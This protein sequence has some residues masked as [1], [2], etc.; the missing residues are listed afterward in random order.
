[1]YLS[2]S[3][4]FSDMNL[5]GLAGWL[6]VQRLEEITHA[7]KMYDY[8]I[9]RGGR[10]L[11]KAIDGPPTE[12]DSPLACAE[13]ILG[14]EQKVTGMIN[15]LVD[16]AIELKDHATNSFLQ[17]YVDEQVEEE[18][19]AG[20]VVEKLRRAGDSS[21]SVLMVDNEMGQ[22]VFNP[23]PKGIHGGVG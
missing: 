12:W 16:L 22:R 2:M 5:P 1:M 9:S 10:V 4:Y 15:S 18:E 8:V 19:S 23:A 7:M 20:E 13:A 11:L 21:Q 14:H 6:R 17:W 3:A